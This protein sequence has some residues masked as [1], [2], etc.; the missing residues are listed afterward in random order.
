[1]FKRICLVTVLLVT[2]ASTAVFSTQIQAATLNVSGGQLLG[3]SN[4]DVGGNL[5]DV[6]FADGSCIS[7]FDGCDELSD[8]VFQT[9]QDAFA[10][11]KALFIQVF[12][13]AIVSFDPD[14]ALTFGCTD[15]PVCQAYTPHGVSGLTVAFANNRVFSNISLFV[16]W[17]AGIPFDAAL[18]TSS[19]D[20]QVYALWTPVNPVPVPAAVWLF[21][22][23]LIG[24]FGYSRRRKIG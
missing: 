18:D 21:G 11:S 16:G 24:F 5:Y 12:E 6:L 13:E 19:S 22:T 10:A 9:E 3:A 2:G 20:S 1:M 15:Q 14:P 4:V 23:A 8:F 7:L 17:V